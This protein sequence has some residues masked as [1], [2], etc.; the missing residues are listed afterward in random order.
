MK[1]AEF[2]PPR[3]KPSIKVEV[4]SFVPEATCYS[5]LLK[6]TKELYDCFA[7]QLSKQIFSEKFLWSAT[8]EHESLSRLATL[9]LPQCIDNHGV[10]YPRNF[11]HFTKDDTI[12]IYCTHLAGEVVWKELKDTPHK[13]LLFCDQNYATLGTFMGVPV[14]SP[15]E[16][17][18]KHKKSKIIITSNNANTVVLR[19]L[20]EHEFEHYFT[21][22]YEKQYFDDILS[23]TE[24]E[25][26]CDCGVLDG[27]TSIQFAEKVQGKYK[28]LH[29]FEPDSANRKKT[30]ENMLASQLKNYEIHPVGVWNKQE[31]LQFVMLGGA[32]TLVESNRSDV[33]E[34]LSKDT[35]I[36]IV[37]VDTLDHIFAETPQEELPTYIKMDIEG[38][39]LQ[40]LQGAKAIIQKAKPKLAISVYHKDEDIVTLLLL[41]KHLHSDYQFYLRHYS[42]SFNETILYA[43]P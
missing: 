29:L 27:E 31:E 20:K 34:K 16:L 2:T 8:K 5:D 10:I 42:N 24:E 19:F 33:L 23:F 25:V 6:K 26:F 38:A 35:V 40:A 32:S 30:Q 4:D 15:Q 14:I 11:S 41:I 17:V 22:F 37:P 21:Y 43:I 3:A 7:D 36:E 18:E 9:S 1:N 39:E 12:V 28:K 13:Q